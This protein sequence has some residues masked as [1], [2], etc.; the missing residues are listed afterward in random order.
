MKSL[1]I[2]AT[3]ALLAV[4]AAC[5]ASSLTVTQ[6]NLD[7]VQNGMSAAQVKAILGNPTDSKS[8]PIPIVGGTKTTFTYAVDGNQVVVVLKND[9]VQSKEGH[10]SAK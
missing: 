3:A 9:E 7:K 5:N 10:F 8:E 2:C 1:R 4:L 6:A